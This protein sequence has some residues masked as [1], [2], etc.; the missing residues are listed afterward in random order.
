MLLAPKRP[1]G[2]GQLDATRPRPHRTAAQAILY[3][4]V[5]V[6]HRPVPRAFVC[7]VRV[8]RDSPERA[9][10]LAKLQAL[11]RERHRRGRHRRASRCRLK[12]SMTWGVSLTLVVRR[13][14]NRVRNPHACARRFTERVNLCGAPLRYSSR[15]PFRRSPRMPALGISTVRLG[16]GSAMLAM[17]RRTCASRRRFVSGIHYCLANSRTDSTGWGPAPVRVRGVPAKEPVEWAFSRTG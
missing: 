13:L 1:D 3:W 6:D 11:G 10:D 4:I 8:G 14:L 7:V 2:F 17:C 5:L 12:A 9:L 15:K 16:G